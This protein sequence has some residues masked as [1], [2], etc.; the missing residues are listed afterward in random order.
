M[1]VKRSK[2]PSIKLAHGSGILVLLRIG[3]RHG[4]LATDRLWR[5]STPESPWLDLVN[6]LIT[7]CSLSLAGVPAVGI[8]QCSLQRMISHGQHSDRTYIALRPE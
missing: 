4:V 1:L 8:L 3:N 2:I 6:L 7:L 5:V